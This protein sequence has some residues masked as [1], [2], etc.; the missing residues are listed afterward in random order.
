MA[1][2]L[3]STGIPACAASCYV[4]CVAMRGNVGCVGLTL[5]TNDEQNEVAIRAKN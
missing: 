3:G 2:A 4:L 1:I 5:R